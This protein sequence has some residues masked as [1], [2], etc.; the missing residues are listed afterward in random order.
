MFNAQRVFGVLRRQ[1]KRMPPAGRKDL[2][3]WEAQ[4]VRGVLWQVCLLRGP[5]EKPREIRPIYLDLHRPECLPVEWEPFAFSLCFQAT[6]AIPDK[7]LVV[8]F[9]P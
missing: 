5:V 6:D 7:W 1:L 2:T 4:I 9:C 8:V 3:G